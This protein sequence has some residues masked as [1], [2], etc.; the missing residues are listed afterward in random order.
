MIFLWASQ[1]MPRLESSG[2]E[3][4]IIRSELLP[5]VVLSPEYCSLD[6]KVLLADTSERISS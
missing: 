2:N 3:V 1:Y 4:S 5:I 6:D